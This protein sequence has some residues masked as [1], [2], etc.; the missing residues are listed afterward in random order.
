M[1]NGSG[2][3]F[4]LPRMAWTWSRCSQ[5][6]GGEGGRRAQPS[7]A[8]RRGAGCGA[9]PS[10]AGA[11]HRARLAVARRAFDRRADGP[12][13]TLRGRRTRRRRRP[14]HA[15]HLRCPR[16]KGAA[17][18]LP[19][20]RAR[21]SRSGKGRSSA[22]QP[23]QPS[24]GGGQPAP[25]KAQRFTKNVA[26]V[27]QQI[28]ASGVT[29]LRSVARAIAFALFVIAR[30]VCDVAT[31]G[32]APRHGSM[33]PWIATPKPARNDGS[34]E[35]GGRLGQMRLPWGVAVI[36][37]T[38]G[39]RTAR[40]ERWA[41]TQYR[42]LYKMHQTALHGSTAVLWRLVARYSSQSPEPGIKLH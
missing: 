29:S 37:N 39:V 13:R 9:A 22:G 18:N 8:A 1:L 14:P 17:H 27:V 35:A 42:S 40:G 33:L 3:P 5:K 7:P 31:Q 41:A 10:R 36:L 16:R 38:R 23:D 11:G 34:F 19:S 12:A 6:G 25:Q 26:L 28:R 15:A 30:S 4:L 21:H 24:R 2:A 32:D 20:G